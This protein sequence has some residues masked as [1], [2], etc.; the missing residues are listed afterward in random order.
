M[1]KRIGFLIS[2]ILLISLLAASEEDYAV[3]IYGD[4]T[5]SSLYC[6]D[7][8]ANI[9]TATDNQVIEDVNIGVSGPALDAIGVGQEGLSAGIIVTPQSEGEAYIIQNLALK[10]LPGN[11][12]MISD[13]QAPIILKDIIIESLGVK[14]QSSTPV[15]IALKNARNVSIENC[16][17]LKGSLFR[18]SNS[19]NIQ[20][21]ND[22]ARYFFLEGIEN[23]II[24]NCTAD[25]IMLKGAI[26]QFYSDRPK[27]LSNATI[28]DDLNMPE[29][30]IEI[31]RNCTIKN[32]NRVNEI[33]LFNA[34]DCTIES[35]T[36]KD[37][38]LWMGN[39]RNATVSNASVVNGTLSIDWSRDLVFRNLTL[40]NSDISMAG[41][42]PEDFSVAFED[43]QVDGMPI[44]Y[45]ENQK[46]LELK[47]LTAGQIWLRECPGAHIDGC[48][49]GEIYVIDS[50]GAVIE[51]SKIDGEGIDLI[52]S[53]D[54]ILSNN[55]LSGK[56][57]DGE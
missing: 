41:S 48:A 37:V 39:A 7:C 15:G 3:V 6:E 53:E 10:G 2:T 27:R 33:D 36:M 14:S 32:C 43:C 47:N 44:L 12:I 19:H 20:I 8:Y 17:A 23:S 26:S 22:T 29:K 5:D 25:C 55:I 54:C 18:I 35:C 16:T 24:D 38:G 57:V 1:I 52:F 42:V 28:Y 46:Q 4:D 13:T 21:T 45:Y 50:D 9:I 31:S 30:I 56:G 34:E 49:A 51:N 11:G 40:I